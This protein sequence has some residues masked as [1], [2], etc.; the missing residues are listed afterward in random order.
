[1]RD[2]MRLDFECPQSI[3]TARISDKAIV[4]IFT[5]Q[6]GYSTF[7]LQTMLHFALAMATWRP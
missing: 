3:F 7:S 1:M 6:F 5:I 4:V 2:N